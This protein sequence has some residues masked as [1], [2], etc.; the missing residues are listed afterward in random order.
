MQEFMALVEHERCKRGT[1]IINF[2]N[3]VFLNIILIYIFLEVRISSN[4][5]IEIH[6]SM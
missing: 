3:C 5:L 2:T 6:L 1:L 4:H